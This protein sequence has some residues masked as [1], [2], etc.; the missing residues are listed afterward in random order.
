LRRLLILLTSIILLAALGFDSALGQPLTPSLTLIYTRAN[1]RIGDIALTSSGEVLFTNYPSKPGRLWL[2]IGG[3][4]KLVYEVPKTTY[5]LYGVA[6]SKNGDIY[7]SCP[8][9]GAI[10][11]IARSGI[12]TVYVRANK[13]VGPLAFAPNGTLYFAELIPA[14]GYQSVFKLVPSTLTTAS[15]SMVAVPVFTSPIT[16]GGIAFNSKGELFFSD[17]PRG[18]LWKLVN[19][20]PVLYVDRKGW[21]TMY[22]IVFDK[23]DNLYFCDWSSPGNIY[24]LDFRLNI[25]YRFLDS[26]NAP[27][28]GANV[29]IMMPNGSSKTFTSNSTGHVSL[30]KVWPGTYALNVSWYGVPVGSF[31]FEESTS[32]SRNLTCKVFNVK[33]TAKDDAGRVLK[34]CILEATLPNGTTVRLSSPAFLSSIPAGLMNIRTFYRSVEV[35]EPIQVNISSNVD[36]SIPCRVYSL[37]ISL[38]DPDG[39]PLKDAWIKVSLGGSTLVNQSYPESGIMLDG[40]LSGSCLIE[41][42]LRGFIVAK[43]SFELNSSHSVVLTANVSKLV[44]KARDLLGFPMQGVRV[45]LTL[46]DGSNASGFTDING[47][48]RLSWL[49]A[50]NVNVVLNYGFEKRILSLSLYKSLVEASQVFIFSWATVSVVIVGLLLVLVIAPPSRRLIARAFPIEVSVEGRGVAEAYIEFLSSRMLSVEEA[51]EFKN[52]VASIL[53]GEANVLPRLESAVNH[54]VFL[55]SDSS[56]IPSRKEIHILVETSRPEDVKVV[57]KLVKE[58]SEKTS[59]KVVGIIVCDE[60]TDGLLS[61]LKELKDVEIVFITRRIL[62]V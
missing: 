22:G 33:L 46:P 7:I 54:A 29:L 43:S 13:N 16:I 51:L 23:Y 42:N 60:V 27:L 58:Y 41:A 61:L 25:V 32:G 49:P 15:G 35:A 20:T 14:E 3:F 55:I 38:L 24:Y 45:D 50:G 59:L 34:D 31:R 44:V 21:S 5:D 30:T 26:N 52:G 17:G 12:F 37:S 36:V 6:V 48:F 4:E 39:N 9:T 1:G 8:Y 40:L 18:R 11:E 53:V 57:S 19:G 2:L 28:A 62:G 56:V 47:S 10:L